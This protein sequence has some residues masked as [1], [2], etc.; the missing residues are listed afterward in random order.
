MNPSPHTK[1]LNSIYNTLV[2]HQHF[3]QSKCDSTM[4][5]YGDSSPDAMISIMAALESSLIQIN[6]DLRLL[7]EEVDRAG[8]A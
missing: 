3:A 4:A 6:S 5:G 2:L 7:L 8:W 1:R